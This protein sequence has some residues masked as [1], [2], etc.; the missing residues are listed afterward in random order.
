MYSKSS[1]KKNTLPPNP[2]DS[3]VPF[4]NLP[5]NPP[6]S[7][8]SMHLP[9]LPPSPDRLDAL[10]LGEVMLR[11]DPGESRVRATRQFQVWEGGGE[12]NVVRGLRKCFGLR[13]A[14]ATALP[15][16]D[17]GYLAEDLILQ[18]GVDTQHILWRE[19]DGIGS[20]TRMGLNFTERGFG[21]RQPMGC[22]DRAHSSASQIRP[23]EFN[24][25]RIFGEGGIRWFHTGGIF[26]ALSPSTA[27]TLLEAVDVAKKHGTIVS[28]DMNY[29]PSLW[30]SRGGKTAADRLNREIASLVDVVMGFDWENPDSQETEFAHV[31]RL[32]HEKDRLR[33]AVLSQFPSARIAATTV[34]QASSA[35][36][37]DWRGL[38]MVDN[39][40]YTSQS[41][42]QLEIL[43]RVGGGDGFATGIVHGFL[44]DLPPQ[45]IVDTAT[46]LGVLAMT[47]PGDNAMVRASEVEALL[48]QSKK[49]ANR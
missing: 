21:L 3:T 30:K 38:L 46:A 17:L 33:E 34:R 2:A 8:C 14:I 18:G 24:W 36:Q 10:A 23:G 22:S 37:N 41:Y 19:F 31:E 1:P 6:F 16:N 48:S 11:F 9:I 42:Q 12:Y 7:E 47:T 28:Y 27:E 35:T 40:V 5:I 44:A 43:D 39:T 15:D 26:A 29:R 32:H 20:K 45:K 49:Y 25:Q 13:T 4:I